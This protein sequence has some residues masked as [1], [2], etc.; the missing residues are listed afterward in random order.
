MIDFSD[1]DNKKFFD[2]SV[3]IGYQDKQSLAGLLAD[4]LY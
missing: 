4:E 2:Y 3:R 1:N